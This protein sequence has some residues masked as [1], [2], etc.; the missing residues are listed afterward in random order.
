MGNI[1]PVQAPTLSHCPLL[2]SQT[3]IHVF[4]KKSLHDDMCEFLIAWCLCHNRGLESSK[5]KFNLGMEYGGLLFPQLVW[6]EK[7]KLSPWTVP[8]TFLSK[9]GCVIKTVHVQLHCDYCCHLEG[10]IIILFTCP[11]AGLRWDQLQLHC[12]PF[13]LTK[14]IKSSTEPPSHSHQ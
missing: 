4:R 5:I 8:V 12:Y 9:H 1:L 7:L 3:I 6:V 14:T 13:Q 11:R 10:W 2:N